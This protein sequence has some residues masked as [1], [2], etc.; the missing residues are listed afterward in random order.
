M[1]PQWR[2]RQCGDVHNEFIYDTIDG[3]LGIVLRL[4]FSAGA[5]WLSTVVLPGITVSADT[6]WG[7][8]GTVILVAAIFG[9]VNALLKPI[10]KLVGCGLYVLTLGLVALVANGLLFWLVSWISGLVGIPF[11]VA[12]FWP[13]AILGALLVGVTSWL[14]G[15]V[16]ADRGD[17]RETTPVDGVAI[18]A[19]LPAVKPVVPSTVVPSRQ[20]TN[21]ER[22][23]DGQRDEHQDAGHAEDLRI[24]FYDVEDPGEGL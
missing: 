13:D 6:V 11:H 14:L 2:G 20:P 19:A 16:I 8:I 5:V 24:G 3:M 1:S 7:T 22:V 23:I 9:L 4:V 12:S 18:A 21:S 15:L 17:L 10:V